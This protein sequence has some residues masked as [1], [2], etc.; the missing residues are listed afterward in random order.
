M[1]AAGYR[2]F[3]FLVCPVSGAV[4]D[5]EATHAQLARIAPMKVASVE[6][7][8]YENYPHNRAVGHVSTCSYFKMHGGIAQKTGK[9]LGPFDSRFTATNSGKGT[10]RPFHW[11][12]HCARI[13]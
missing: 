13:S 1:I 3:T 9:W 8:V 4:L 12:P 2:G 6:Y 5:D 11:C 7:W 10:G